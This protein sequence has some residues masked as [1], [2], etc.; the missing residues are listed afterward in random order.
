MARLITRNTLSKSG[1]DYIDVIWK[2][3]PAAFQRGCVYAELKS[4]GQKQHTTTVRLDAR[5]K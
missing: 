2:R 4:I 5:T 3:L 1:F